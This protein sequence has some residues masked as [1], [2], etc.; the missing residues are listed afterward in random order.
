MFYKKRIALIFNNSRQTYGATR[1]TKQLG[2]EGINLSRS[3]VGLLMKQLGL[4]SILSKKYRVQTTD[5][6]HDYPITE[7]VLNRNFSS[8]VLGQ[9]WVSDI[10]YIKIANKWNYIT[11]IMDLADRKVLSCVLSQDLSTKNTVYKAWNMARRQRTITADHIFHSD[12][13]VQYASNLMRKLCD[14]NHNITQS[15]SRKGNCWDNAVAESF[16]KP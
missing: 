4:K 10:T 2:R 5:S 6:N 13:G 16:L 15:M 1:I 14:S 9:K 7:N 12:R 3:Y 8:S 11:T